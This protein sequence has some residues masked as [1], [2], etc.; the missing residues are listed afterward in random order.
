[1]L[2][3][4]DTRALAHE[5]IDGGLVAHVTC[6]DPRKLDRAFAGRRFDRAFLADLPAGTDP[7]GENGEFHSFVSD[8]PLFAG[9]VPVRGGDVVERDGF[10]FA[11][12][13]PIGE[14][15]PGQQ[16]DATIDHMR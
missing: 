1:P 5:M 8:G 2:W 11:D 14:L 6:I 7:C 3:G 4:R 16:E 15:A 9:P 13:L 10:V 12:M